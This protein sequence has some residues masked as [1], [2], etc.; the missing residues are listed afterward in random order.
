MQGETDEE[1]TIDPGTWGTAATFL[2]GSTG[3]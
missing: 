2:S 3:S 1:H